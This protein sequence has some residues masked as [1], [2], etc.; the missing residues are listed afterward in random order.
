MIKVAPS[1]PPA[2][3]GQQG[4]PTHAATRQVGALRDARG[5]LPLT[6]GTAS[7]ANNNNDKRKEDARC[8]HEGYRA[9]RGGEPRRSPHVPGSLESWSW[10]GGWIEGNDRREKDARRA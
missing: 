6:T 7:R 10:T 2:P 8:W 9:G 4:P 1:L 5:S 3:V